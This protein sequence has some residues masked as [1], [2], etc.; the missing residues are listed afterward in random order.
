MGESELAELAA[1]FLAGTLP[2]ERWTHAAHLAVGAWHV[3]HLGESVAIDT[4]RL[5]IRKLNTAHGTQNTS[6]GGY[7]ETIT[8][9]YVRLIAAFLAALSGDVPL[10]QRVSALLES[11]LAERTFLFRFW[12]KSL[13]MSAEARAN[14]VAPDLLPLEP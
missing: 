13:L 8:V 6:T 7:H 2:R 14:W 5:G 3:H 9:A 1:A 4:L 12:S 11:P 10:E